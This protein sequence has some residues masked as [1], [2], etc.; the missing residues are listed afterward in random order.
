[1]LIKEIKA[2]LRHFQ[3]ARGDTCGEV[4][5]LEANIERKGNSKETYR[6]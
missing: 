6:V 2:T 3:N 5:I 4:L 1:M